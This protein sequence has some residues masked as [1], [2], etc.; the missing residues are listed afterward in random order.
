MRGTETAQFP[1]ALRP[2]FK[3]SRYKCLYG[4]RGGGKSHS[5]AAYLLQ[6]TTQ[7]PLRILCCREFQS[8]I[9]ESVHRLLSDKIAA[10]R[11]ADRF[12]VL[13]KSIRVHNGSEFIF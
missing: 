3:P 13:E 11:L 6:I 9:R 2:L 10:Y 7:R 5:V 12:E 4:G 1:T 8:S